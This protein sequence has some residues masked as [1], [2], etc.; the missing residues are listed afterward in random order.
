MNSSGLKKTLKL[1]LNLQAASTA[2]HLLIDLTDCQKFWLPKVGQ[3]LT[4]LLVQRFQPLGCNF[5]ERPANGVR[6]QKLGDELR[7]NAVTGVA[8]PLGGFQQA[9]HCGAGARA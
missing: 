5:Y 6:W 1:A 7:H 9:L 2:H 3:A 8:A 4:G